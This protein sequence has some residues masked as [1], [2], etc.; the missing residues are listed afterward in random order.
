MAGGGCP[1]RLSY[2][3]DFYT[4]DKIF[5]QDFGNIEAHGELSYLNPSK[6]VEFWSRDRKEKLTTVEFEETAASKGGEADEMPPLREFLPVKRESPWPV[7]LP[8]QLNILKVVNKYYPS[9]A[10]PWIQDDIHYF[11]P[12]STV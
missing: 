9:G 8:A 6:V 12:S 3:F 2:R 7:K 5:L 11:D 10:R 4:R 1:R